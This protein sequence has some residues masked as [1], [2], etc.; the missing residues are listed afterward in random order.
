M[1]AISENDY[2]EA[3]RCQIVLAGYP[4]HSIL[5]ICL[6]LFCAFFLNFNYNTGLTK[7][8]SEA[9]EENWLLPVVIAVVVDLRK[10][11]H[12]LDV[13]SGIRITEGDDTSYSSYLERVAQSIM[14]LFQTCA[15]DG[16]VLY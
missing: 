2:D 15:A 14:R 7:A 13:T 12:R 1:W 3:C 11:A 5:L 4:F 9:Q 10:F 8:F 16:Y 6:L